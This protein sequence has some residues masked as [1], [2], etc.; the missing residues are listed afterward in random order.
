MASRIQDITVEIDGDTTK[1][2]KALEGVNKSI[3]G[4]QSGLKDL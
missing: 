3:R 4:T 1:L 2:P